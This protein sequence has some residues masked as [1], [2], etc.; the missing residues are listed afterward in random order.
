MCVPGKTRGTDSSSLG[1]WQGCQDAGKRSVVVKISDSCPCNHPN[2]SN[3]RWCCGD[4][5]HFD[6]SYSAFD[7]IAQRD[8]GVVDLKVRQVSCDL[9]GQTIYYQGDKGK[10]GKDKSKGK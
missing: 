1:P 8:R 5:Q 9:Q 3:K 6:L 10:D 4:A 7:V 2:T